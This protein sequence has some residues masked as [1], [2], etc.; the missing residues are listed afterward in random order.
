MTS[1]TSVDQALT[2]RKTFAQGLSIREH[3]NLGPAQSFNFVKSG[4]A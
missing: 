3:V 2:G 1:Q 4:F